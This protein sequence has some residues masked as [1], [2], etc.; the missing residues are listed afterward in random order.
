MA[1]QTLRSMAEGGICDHLGGGFHRYAVDDIW[2]V[3]HFEKM[4]YDQAQLAIS[5]LEAYQL[6]Q[7]TFFAGVARDIF[8]YVLRDMTA[9]GGGFF[10]AEDADSPLPEDPTKSGEGAFYMWTWDEIHR[11]LGLPDAQIFATRFGLEQTGNVHNDPHDEFAGKNIL[12][13]AH[14]LDGTASGV[15]LPRDLVRE[16][17]ANACA[18]LL[19]VRSRRPRPHLDDKVLT[20]WNGLMISAFARGAQV[21]DDP[22]YAEAARRAALFLTGRMWNQ[23]DGVL[24]RRFR[25]DDAAIPGFL[26]DYAFFAQALIDLYETDFDFGCL[27]SAIAITERMMALFEDR[28]N[29]AFFTTAAGG[30][31]LVLRIKDDYDGA[32]PSGNSIAILN[33]LRLARVTGR[34]DFLDSAERALRALA[35]RVTTQPSA[36][37]QLLVALM[38][39]HAHPRQIILAGERTSESTRAFLR[40][41]HQRFLPDSVVLLLDSD[42]ARARFEKFNPAV[43]EMRQANG[44]TRA[45]VCRDYA[46]ELP[47]EDVDRFTELLK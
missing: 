36:V 47:T 18:K 32:E 30:D 41:L 8:R 14:N 13:V 28:E 24:L 26:D 4:L 29:G 12:F 17:L 23:G 37:P 45:Y 44:R 33:L 2:F 11:E 15:G 1:L 6:T 3:P 38:Y 31:D 35:S 25:R 34:Q 21:L 5:Y 42:E 46:C 19:G 43:A 16:K 27:E 7:D 40:R 10:S 20:S 9:P 22:A 39:A